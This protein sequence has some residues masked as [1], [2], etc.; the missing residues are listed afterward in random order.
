VVH[1]SKEFLCRVCKL[2]IKNFWNFWKLQ[3][4]FSTVWTN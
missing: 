1:K 3:K 2:Q 4:V